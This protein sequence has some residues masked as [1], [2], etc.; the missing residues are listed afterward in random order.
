MMERLNQNFQFRYQTAK[1]GANFT[2]ACSL[3]IDGVVD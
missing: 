3:T 2:R 1:H